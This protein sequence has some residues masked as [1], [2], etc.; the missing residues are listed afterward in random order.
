MRIESTRNET[1]FADFRHAD[2]KITMIVDLACNPLLTLPVFLDTVATVYKWARD[3]VGRIVGD[4]ESNAAPWI[5][6]DGPRYPLPGA[7][8]GPLHPTA[9][10]VGAMRRQSVPPAA[11][12][13]T[14]A[15]RPPVFPAPSGHTCSCR[16]CTSSSGAGTRV[17]IRRGRGRAAWSQRAYSRCTECRHPAKTA[18]ANALPNIS[19]ALFV[20]GMPFDSN[21]IERAFHELLGSTS[22]LTSR[23]GACGDG[24]GRGDSRAHRHVHE[25]RDRPGR[26]ALHAAGRP[27]LTRRRRR[28]GGCA[29]AARPAPARRHD[30]GRRRAASPALPRPQPCR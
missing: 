5:G 29:A 12:S 20:E 25:E 13:M 8:S 9:A 27:K 30:K 18:I 24:H 11:I 15:K 16:A 23:C 6:D 28:R 7:V 14:T 10:A 2:S 4:P 3:G 21:E 1:F 17:R 22:S 26:R 19:C